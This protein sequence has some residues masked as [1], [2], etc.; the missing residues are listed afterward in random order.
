M[1]EIRFG[2]FFAIC[3]LNSDD[4]VMLLKRLLL[5]DENCVTASPN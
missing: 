3:S 1:R 4:E 2:K 5:S